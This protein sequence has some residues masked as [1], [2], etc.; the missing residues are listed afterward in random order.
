MTENRFPKLASDGSFSV[1]IIVEVDALNAP[2]VGAI[3]DWIQSEWGPRNVQ[4]VQVWNRGLPSEE[5]V[6]LH[7]ADDFTEL[8]RAVELRDGRLRLRLT[9]KPGA[10]WWRDWLVRLWWG[11]QAHFPAIG[12]VHAA[13]NTVWPRDRVCPIQ[14]TTPLF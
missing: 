11:L 5:T 10:R 1:D 3:Q 6:V 13:E 7:Y 9:G 12:D 8:P 4:W 14:N 2:D